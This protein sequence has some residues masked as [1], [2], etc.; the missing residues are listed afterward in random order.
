MLIVL[1]VVLRTVGSL[2]VMLDLLTLRIFA[3]RVGRNYCIDRR[4]DCG[5][6]DCYSYYIVKEHKRRAQGQQQ[7]S[8][9]ETLPLSLHVPLA[10]FSRSSYVNTLALPRIVDFV[11]RRL[12]LLSFIL[13]KEFIIIAEEGFLRDECLSGMGDFLLEPLFASAARFIVRFFGY[14]HNHGKKPLPNPL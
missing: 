8:K 6:G 5:H 13:V 4:G 14:M 2:R 3:P 11:A 9:I 1:K 12:L 10:L 7:H